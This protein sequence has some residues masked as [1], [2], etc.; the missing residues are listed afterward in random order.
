MI[1]LDSGARERVRLDALE[2]REATF[3]ALLDKRA[4][5]HDLEFRAQ[6]QRAFNLLTRCNHYA[7]LEVDFIGHDPRCGVRAQSRITDFSVWVWAR[8]RDEPTPYGFWYQTTDRVEARYATNC[9]DT[10]VRALSRVLPVP[11]PAA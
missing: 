10:L 5:W 8:A 9:P 11:P 6:W 7:D 4:P 3:Y 2:K 1:M